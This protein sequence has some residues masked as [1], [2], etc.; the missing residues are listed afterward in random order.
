MLAR[1]AENFSAGDFIFGENLSD[2]RIVIVK[3]LAQKKHRPF[4]G[5]QSF[6]QN[7]KSH[8]QRL[9]YTKERERIGVSFSNDRLRQPLPHVLLTLDS[10]RLKVVNT[11]TADHRNQ[12]SPRGSDFLFGC[13]L[14]PDKGFLQ[15]VFG[16][17]YASQHPISNRKE[18]SAISIEC[19]RSI[20]LVHDLVP[21]LAKCWLAWL[22]IIVWLRQRFTPGTAEARSFISLNN[23]DRPNMHFV[24]TVCTIELRFAVGSPI[25]RRRPAWRATLSSNFGPAQA[26]LS[27]RLPCSLPRT[28]IALGPKFLS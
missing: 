5:G 21:Q 7:E 26:L 20:S 12:K 1:P 6:E 24:T 9:I 28:L 25:C 14:P 3:Y 13:P 4:D 16:V 23:Y 17:R 19:L 27:T 15:H 22:R 8:R 10:H 18:Q 2:R 11:K